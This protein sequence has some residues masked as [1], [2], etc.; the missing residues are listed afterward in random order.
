MFFLIYFF[1]AFIKCDKYLLETK[2]GH[3]KIVS[4]QANPETLEAGNDYS[5][6]TGSNQ[7]DRMKELLKRAKKEL[8]NHPVE[9]GHTQNKADS[10][11]LTPTNDN[12]NASTET[13][14]DYSDMEHD[15]SKQHKE[16]TQR[17]RKIRKHIS[18]IEKGL[19][20]LNHSAPKSGKNPKTLTETGNDY[21]NDEKEITTQP[22]INHL[23]TTKIDAFQPEHFVSEH[24]NH[25]KTLNDKNQSAS[26]ETGHDYSDTSWEDI[27]PS[28][29]KGGKKKTKKDFQKMYESRMQTWKSSADYKDKYPTG[30]VNSETTPATFKPKKLVSEHINNTKILHDENKSAS[31]ETGQDYSDTDTDTDTSWEDVHGTTCAPECEGE[32]KCFENK[33]VC[34]KGFVLDPPNQC[35]ADSGEDDPTGQDYSQATPTCSQE[36]KKHNE[37]VVG[38]GGTASIKCTGGCI[39]FAKTLFDCKSNTDKDNDPGHLAIAKKDCEGK[40]SCGLN[41]NEQLFGKVSGC[42]S[43]EFK[44]SL[45]YYCNGGQHGF[46]YNFKCDASVT[47]GWSEENRWNS[48]HSSNKFDSWGNESNVV[49]GNNGNTGNREVTR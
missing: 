3:K 14:N 23:P 12:K 40:E 39:T 31:T 47:S 10:Q 20:T 11:T 27:D 33:C 24:I 41:Y 43:S 46:S 13:G 37:E 5:D 44:L 38:C 18:K 15:M 30:Q 49:N 28:K 17:T 29:L 34:K 48:T 8:G 6:S 45:E 4:D 36:G 7:I 21:S 2:N 1:I 19:K 9:E 16:E 35:N 22:T 26:T 32:A 25:N 42:K